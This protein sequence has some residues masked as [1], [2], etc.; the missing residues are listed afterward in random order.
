M[1]LK[2]L[3]IGILIVQLSAKAQSSNFED[4]KIELAA[5]LNYSHP[6]NIYRQGLG[7]SIGFGFNLGGKLI[8]VKHT[9]I[10]IMWSLGI[11]FDYLWYGGEQTWVDIYSVNVNSNAYGWA[12]YTILEFGG[13]GDFKLYGIGM[14]GFYYYAGKYKVDW[15][16]ST[17]GVSSTSQSHEENFAPDW[18]LFTGIGGGFRVKIFDVRVIANF[19]TNVNMLDPGSFN[20]DSSGQL[21]DYKTIHTNTNKFIVSM[22]IRI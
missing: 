10:P 22:G 1:H 16:T 12:P 19:G 13:L 5:R 21:S 9:Q 17:V 7:Q 8:D 3:L 15:E 20:L 2:L 6:A 4:S 14:A 11:N 18:S